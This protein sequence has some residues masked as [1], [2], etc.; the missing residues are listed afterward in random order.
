MAAA[1]VPGAGEAGEGA[2][3]LAGRTTR[4]VIGR[5]AGANP[6]ERINLAESNAQ[7]K[8]ALT[9]LHARGEAVV[10]HDPS[11][12][13][14]GGSEHVVEQADSG[15]FL[16]HTM[17]GFGGVLEGH[18][19]PFGGYLS[20]REATPQEYLQRMDASNHGER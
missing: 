13:I 2:E 19:G 6:A 18:V 5:V 3:S 15:R 7:Q 14:G 17:E 12:I 9:S 1:S 16:K 20:A 4:D 11:R 10:R 8:A